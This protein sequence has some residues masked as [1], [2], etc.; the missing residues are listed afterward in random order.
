LASSSLRL[1]SYEH[2]HDSLT[3]FTNG[4]R[5]GLGV[6][7][8]G[9]MA[10]APSASGLRA[11][12]MLVF[13]IAGGMV[14][15]E[16]ASLGDI[17][18]AVSI[19]SASGKRVCYEK[20]PPK[21]EQVNEQVQKIVER[22]GSEGRTPEQIALTVGEDERTVTS[23]LR[24]AKGW[25]L[26]LDQRICIL[27]KARDLHDDATVEINAHAKGKIVGSGHVPVG[28]LFRSSSGFQGPVTCTTTRKLHNFIG[29]LCKPYVEAD[30]TYPVL[31][32]DV[33][34]R[35]YKVA[36]GIPESVDISI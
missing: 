15:R 24:K 25:N 21:F 22:L 11:V 33:R 4:L 9:E 27:V 12:A 19:G 28:D 32:M 10:S 26:G 31:E 34:M 36:D 5:Q 2:H 23:I 6:K 1:Q 29:G 13:E 20:A 16:A 8:A 35:L 14:S 3:S 7:A 30:G 17:T 18:L